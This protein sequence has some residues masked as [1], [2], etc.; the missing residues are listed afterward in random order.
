YT[1]TAAGGEAVAITTARATGAITACWE[2]FAPDGTAVIGQVCGQGEAILPS[3]SGVYTIKV[4][5]LGLDGTGAYAVTL[6]A[7]SATSN[8]VSNGPPTPTCQRGT[9]GTQPIL[10]GETKSGSIDVVG[11]T[12]T[13]TFTAAG[14][15]AVAITTARA[16]GAITACWELFAPDGT[17]V[18]GQVCG[19]GEAIMPSESGVYTIKVFDSGL[20]GTGTYNF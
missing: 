19:Q 14:G 4:F 8:G 13:Y 20:D 7:V 6:E 11:E 15:E 10:C 2:L 18:I 17:A 5:D 9:D 1:F 12:D 16:T 3:Q